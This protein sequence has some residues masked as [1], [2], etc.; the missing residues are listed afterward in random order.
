[1]DDELIQFKNIKKRFGKKTVLESL[2]L[3][4][5]EGKITG[6]IG[7]SGEGKTTILKLLIGFYSPTE[8]TISYSRRNIYNDMNNIK[9]TFGFAT[10]DGS[11]HERLTVSENLVHFGQ[12]HHM[13]RK[14]VKERAI[15][16][17]RLVG[18]DN[19]MDTLAEN[20]SMGMKKRLD[21]AISLMHHPKVLIMDEPTADLDPLLRDQ[22]LSLIKKIN[23]GGT[24][25]ILTTQLLGEMDKICDK[26]AI[27]FDKRIVDEGHPKSVKNRYDV[28][29][30]DDVFNRIF[31]QRGS[32]MTIQQILQSAKD[33]GKAKDDVNENM[34]E[35]VEPYKPQKIQKYS[36]VDALKKEVNKDE[37]SS[38]YY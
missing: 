21:V 20:L 31:S 27:L 13:T 37:E 15:E 1:M 12:L 35:K 32:G 2:N 36:G 16:V 19:A 22:M 34:E 3:T 4:I 11:F 10:E 25:I 38:K 28:D 18:L 6:I 24:T 8:G 5:P 17:A 23:A 9:N 14:D 29:E 7:A 33:Y 26:I 30:L